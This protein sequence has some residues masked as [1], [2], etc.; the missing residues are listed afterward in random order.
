M[1]EL[2]PLLDQVGAISFKYEKLNDLL[3]YNVFDVIFKNHDEVR[4]HSKFLADLLDPAGFHRKGNE[5]LTEFLSVI[6]ADPIQLK[7]VWV[8]TEYRNIDI[9]ITNENTRQAII[10]ENKIWAEDQLAQLERYE[11]IAREERYSEVQI[12]YLTL[13]GREP[14]EKSLGKLKPGRVKLISYSFEIFSW[15]KR[16]MELSVRNPNL[17]FT[18]S[19]YQDVVAE[20]TGQHMNEEQKNEMFQ[21]I[22]R[23]D[24]VLKAKEI[25]DSWNH[26]K[27]Q[28]E[29]NYWEKMA[30][31]VSANYTILPY[32]KY[33]KE[34]L[35][36]II[37]ASR[38]RDPWYG[39]MFEIGKSKK[40]SVC[41]FIERGFNG[42]YFGLTVHN[43]GDRTVSCEERHKYLEKR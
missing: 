35:D 6:K 41:L 24:N 40:E 37:N 38:N 7:E 32:Q 12:F 17:L 1:T 39:I 27:W 43:K 15:I 29:W 11:E 31:F 3:G 13:D 20:L 8:G 28:T 4:L 16:C 9:F 19:Q 36:G 25:V 10:V 14:S 22:G 21:L 26:I 18:L 2:Q 30:E 23:N 5:F 34:K 42:P 33:S